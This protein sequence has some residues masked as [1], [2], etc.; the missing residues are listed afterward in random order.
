MS[1]HLK[2][3]DSILLPRRRALL[4]GGALAAQLLTGCSIF[5]SAADDRGDT[6]GGKEDPHVSYDGTFGSEILRTAMGQYGKKYAY[7]KAHPK[8][9]F[10]C[11]GLI[12][13]A[14]RQH[15]IK[16]PR[17][18]ALLARGGKPVARSNMRQGDIIVFRIGKRMHAGIVADRGRF[19]H[20]PSS[21]LTVRLERINSQY[22][23]NRVAAIRRYV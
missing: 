8:E 5:K 21:G 17:T 6:G 19:L 4:L 14:F 13:Y 12:W 10:D 23:K 7:G 2:E 16:V 18:S 11:S 20:S 3:K 22:W 1:G 15:G 9:G